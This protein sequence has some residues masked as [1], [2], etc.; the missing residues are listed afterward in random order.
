MQNNITTEGKKVQ[1]E[2]RILISNPL[3]LKRN[4]NLFFVVMSVFC[5][6]NRPGEY[7]N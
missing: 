1:Q 3:S 7:R 6:R 2:E 5:Q 4:G